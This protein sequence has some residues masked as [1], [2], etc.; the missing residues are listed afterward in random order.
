M[1]SF[2]GCKSRNVQVSCCPLLS[3]VFLALLTKNKGE[4]LLWRKDCLEHMHGN[5][6]YYC[7]NTAHKN[8]C[9]C[10][11]SGPVQRFR[12]SWSCLKWDHSCSVLMIPLYFFNY[13]YLFLTWGLQPWYPEMKTGAHRRCW[14]YLSTNYQSAFATMRTQS[15]TSYLARQH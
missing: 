13:I 9:M 11:V 14:G 10:P 2:L 12:Y 5:V 6:I 1:F 7:K 3:M 4:I 15:I 8:N